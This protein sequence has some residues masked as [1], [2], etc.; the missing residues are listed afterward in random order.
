M[1]SQ[2]IGIARVCRTTGGYG[3]TSVCPFTGGVPWPLVPDTFLGY[4]WPLSLAHG[5]F[6]AQVLPNQAGILPPNRTGVHPYAGQDWRIPQDGQDWCTMPNTGRRYPHPTIGGG[7][8][9]TPQMGF[10]QVVCLLWLRR[11]TVL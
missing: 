7:G 2:P 11:R 1:K 9:S 3:F 8:L 6:W 10:P 4:L 5:S